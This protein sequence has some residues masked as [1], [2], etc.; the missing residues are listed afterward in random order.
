M[1]AETISN[2]GAVP[3]EVSADAGYYPPNAVDDLRALG[4]DRSSRRIRRATAEW[5]RRRPEDAYPST[6]L[7]GTGC[8]GSCRPGG[9][10]S[11]TPFAW[12]RW[13]RSSARSRRVG[14]GFRQFL[15]RGLEKVN[16]EWSLICT[17]H[18]PESSSGQA[19]LKLFRFG[20]LASG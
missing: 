19:L 1:I 20:R 10:A 8:G 6:C 17:G 9:A 11:V 15:L 16:G 13:N 5:F 4:V 7:P 18:N 3:R 2:T 12:R 14:G